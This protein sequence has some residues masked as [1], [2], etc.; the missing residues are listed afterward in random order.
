MSSKIVVVGSLNMDLVACASRIP[1]AGETISG[2]TFLSQPGGKG[3]N[4][5]FAAGRLGAHVSMIGKVGQDDFGRRMRV[6]LESVGCDVSGLGT[7][8][9]CSSGIALIFVADSG[10]NSIIVVP[11][12]NHRLSPRDIEDSRANFQGAAAVLLQ[13]ETPLPTVVAAAQ[14]AH[15]AGVLT[16]LDPAPAPA[17][18]LPAELLESTDIITPNES[19]AAILTGLPPGRL[20]VAQAFHVAS[21]LQTQGPRTVIVK[22]GD[23]GCALR[24]GKD[25]ELIPAPKVNAV[26]TTAAGDVFNAALAVALSEGSSISDACRFANRAAA[27]SVTRRGAQ[28]AAP[29]RSEL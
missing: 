27:L 14:A 7:T 16:I 1:I 12:A 24:D 28:Q 25:E 10:Q 17:Q 13:L 3:A 20:D 23:L 18:P 2:H 21:K 6:N 15:R 19:E 4:Q 9:D 29:A 8:A 22:L 5:A 26:D 11:G